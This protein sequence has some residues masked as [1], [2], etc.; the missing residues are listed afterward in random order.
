MQHCM[1]HHINDVSRR[2]LKLVERTQFD[3]DTTWVQVHR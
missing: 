2:F 3:E 1:L